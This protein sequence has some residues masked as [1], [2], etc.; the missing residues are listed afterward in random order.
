MSSVGSFKL[1]IREVT[2]PQGKFIAELTFKDDPKQEVL[3][4][5][6][7]R[8]WK[9]AYSKGLRLGSVFLRSIGELD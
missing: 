6:F 5:R 1:N 4:S 7:G 9:E 2:E 3:L 8:T